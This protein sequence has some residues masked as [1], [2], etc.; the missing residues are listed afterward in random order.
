MAANLMTWKMRFLPQSIRISTVLLALRTNAMFLHSMSTAG[1][2]QYLLQF[3][4][5]FALLFQNSYKP[6][7]HSSDIC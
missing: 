1:M 5:I 6:V 7:R 2:S 3:R 4:T